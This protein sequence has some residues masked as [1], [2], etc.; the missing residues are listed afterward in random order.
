[1]SPE[2]IQALSI[3]QLPLRKRMLE[4]VLIVVILA[5]GMCSAIMYSA[6][7][8]VLPGLSAFFGGGEQGVFLA[9]MVM[10]MPGLGMMIGGPLAGLLIERWGERSV[11]LASLAVFTVTGSAG[12]FLSDAATLLF[13]R[14]MVGVA[15]SGLTT[16]CLT[17]LS[18]RFAL[19]VRVRL[20]GYHSAVGATVGLLAMLG[21][22]VSADLGSWRTPFSF[23][24]LGMLVVLLALFSVPGRSRAGREAAVIKG[25]LRPL[26]PLYICCVPL[27]I[28]VFTTSV[29]APF[30][31]ETVGVLSA[32]M[33]SR[34]LALGVLGHVLGAWLFGTLIAR[35]GVRGSLALGLS[36]MALGH[37]LLGLAQNGA[38]VAIACLVSSLGSGILVPYMTH[39]LVENAPPQLRGRALGLFPVFTFL[40]SLL[41]PLAYA[42]LTTLFGIH[43][44]L[45]AVSAMLGLAV[46]VVVLFSLPR[47]VRQA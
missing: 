46:I 33:Q 42:P 17:L 27:F 34:I 6:I 20:L 9:Q 21:A 2:Q 5:S 25:S 14:F 38:V 8:P 28:A 15:A 11:I 39:M 44:A 36:L 45:L 41:N 22:G 18:W 16:A 3:P 1:M 29:Q 43:G 4:R 10:T 35:L 26:L 23:H 7:T 47:P 24:L 30:L 19:K 13:S 32:G 40:G 31:L 37:L 12:L